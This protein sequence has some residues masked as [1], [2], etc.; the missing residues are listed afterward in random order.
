M[1]YDQNY[2]KDVYY[3]AQNI[4]LVTLTDKELISI[5]YALKK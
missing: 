5:D 2:I 4:D 3:Q 1:D